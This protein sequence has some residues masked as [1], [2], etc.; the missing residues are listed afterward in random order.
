MFTNFEADGQNQF[1]SFRKQVDSET[2]CSPIS[3]NDFDLFQVSSKNQN[4]LSKENK[5]KQD[6]VL[7][8]NLFIMCQ[9]RQLD[10]EDFFIHENQASPPS[11]PMASFTEVPSLI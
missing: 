1:E 9:T 8:S 7:F 5:L 11:A 3:R 6:C 10:L 2:F 4:K